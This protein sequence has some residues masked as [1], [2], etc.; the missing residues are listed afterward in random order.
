MREKYSVREVVAF[1]AGFGLLGVL[2]GWA[3]RGHPVLASIWLVLV[4]VGG[5]LAR[6]KWR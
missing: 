2:V 5:G 1:I 4:L 6:I 3:L